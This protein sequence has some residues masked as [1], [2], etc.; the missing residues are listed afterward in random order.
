M[1]I[2]WHSLPRIRGGVSPALRRWR[3]HSGSSPHTRGCFSRLALGSWP[4]IVFPA[5]AGVF[6]RQ[7]SAFRL[8]ES[9]P[10]IRGGVSRC[11]F[12]VYIDENVFPAYAGVFPGRQGVGIHWHSLPRIRGGVSPALR[13]WRIHSGSSPHTR[14]CFSRLALGSWPCIVFPA[15]AGVFPRQMSAFRLSESLP[16]IRGGVSILS[17]FQAVASESS[18]HTRGCF[19]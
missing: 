10:R 11:C 17:G 5:Y 14:G 15:Y 18:P 19:Y 9:L 13:R 4:C 12:A 2:H 3:I 16:R 8:S 6:P 1:G 7:M